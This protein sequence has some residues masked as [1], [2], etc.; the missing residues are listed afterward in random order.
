MVEVPPSSHARDRAVLDDPVYLYCLADTSSTAG[1]HTDGPDARYAVAPIPLGDIAAIVCRVPVGQFPSGE[2][3]LTDDER[4]QAVALAVHHAQVVERV[5]Q[6]SPVLPAR[7]GTVFRDEDAVR[8]RLAVL[9]GSIR[10]FLKATRDCDEWVV[11]G[12]LLAEQA[13]RSVIATDPDLAARSAL[14]PS[15]PGVRYLQEKQLFAEADRLTGRWV[16][17]KAEQIAAAL[18]NRGIAVHALKPS[19]SR[20]PDFGRP[21]VYQ[22]AFLVPRS[23]RDGWLS[24]LDAVAAKFEPLGLK[25]IGTGPW[26]PSTFA[27]D[28]S[29]VLP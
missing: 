26:P 6:L 16:A 23:N 19:A 2:G 25:L 20:D 7:F 27:S 18:A 14:L 9:G 21:P 29:A 24:R 22:A 28:L 5:F 8:S 1:F 13:R 11:K 15:S 17:D 4:R 12:F 3:E 10:A